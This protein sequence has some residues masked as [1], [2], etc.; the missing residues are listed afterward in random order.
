MYSELWNSRDLNIDC[1]SDIFALKS[2]KA[3]MAVTICSLFYSPYCFPAMVCSGRLHSERN[4]QKYTLNL[5]RWNVVIDRNNS[6]LY[7][8]VLNPQTQ[9]ETNRW[10]GFTTWILFR[11]LIPLFLSVWVSLWEGYVPG[12]RI[13]LTN[14]RTIMW[15]ACII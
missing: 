7:S 9:A 13:S 8:L 15:S 12:N 4:T 5:K 10:W 1:H 3:W 2:Y 11:V 14:E 6:L